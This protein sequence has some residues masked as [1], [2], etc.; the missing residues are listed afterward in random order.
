MLITPER[1]NKV[2]QKFLESLIENGIEENLHLDYKEQ[3]GSNAEIAKDLSSFANNDGGNIIYGMKEV[4][5]KPIEITPQNYQNLREK[6]DKIIEK[7][8]NY[9]FPNYFGLQRFGSFRPN[10]HIVGRLILKGEYM[11]E[12]QTKNDSFP[13]TNKKE[14][15]WAQYLDFTKFIES[16]EN[17]DL[18][19]L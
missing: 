18:E 6:I 3:L 19:K 16:E 17:D 12:A 14:I 2:N 8:R 5:N 9:G 10:S 15:D 11:T 1:F 13:I 7:M 4:D